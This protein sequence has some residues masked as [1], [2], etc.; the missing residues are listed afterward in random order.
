MSLCAQHVNYDPYCRRCNAGI[1]DCA[2]GKKP[3]CSQCGGKGY[4]IGDGTP[5]Y[6]RLEE[7]E[8]EAVIVGVKS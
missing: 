4:Y 7:L 5:R 3:G 1:V 8:G 6:R 2:C